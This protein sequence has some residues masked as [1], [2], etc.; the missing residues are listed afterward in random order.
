MMG[1]CTRKQQKYRHSLNMPRGRRRKTTV[2]QTL[3]LMLA[4][5]MIFLPPVESL[6]VSSTDN[7]RFTVDKVIYE[8]ISESDKTCRLVGYENGLINVELLS[9]DGDNR[10][11]D[12]QPNGYSV[13]EV[14]DEAF[15][16]C[17]TLENV[18]F[19]STI[20]QFGSNVFEGCT[21]I[22]FI[23]NG[24]TAVL[25]LPDFADKNWY[26]SAS[27]LVTSIAQG[28]AVTIGVD[29]Y[30]TVQIKK[31]S[32][33]DAEVLETQKVKKYGTVKKPAQAPE[34]E[35]Y[36][37]LYWSKNNS[38]EY[39]FTTLVE[40]DFTLVPI[41]KEIKTE[42]ECT[43][44]T[45]NY[46]ETIAE[47]FTDKT[48][49]KWYSFEPDKAG[50][51]AFKIAKGVELTDFGT[52]WDEAGVLAASAQSGTKTYTNSVEAG[53]KYYFRLHA[54]KP[55]NSPLVRVTDKEITFTFTPEGGVEPAAKTQ[56]KTL[57][58][59]MTLEY[60]STTY[61]GKWITP[62]VVVKDGSYTLVE[63]TDYTL[64]Y[65]ENRNAGKATVKVEAASDSEK[66]EGSYEMN[67]TITKAS[68][69]PNLPASKREVAS[70]VTK[71][72]DVSLSGSWQWSTADRDKTIN[73][74]TAVEATAEYTGTDKANYT[75]TT[76]KVSIIRNRAYVTSFS[77]K[78]GS[79]A[80]KGKE[81]GQ[82]EITNI[83]PANPDAYTVAWTSDNEKV[84]SVAGN[85][86]SCTVTAGQ[87]GSAVVT[88]EING[89][90]KTCTVTVTNPLTGFTLNSSQE[91]IVAGNSTIL[92]IAATTPEEPDAYTVTW[93]SSNES[94]AAVKAAENKN[95][96]KVTAVSPGT[97]TISAAVVSGG[98][99]YTQSC[100]ITVSAAEAQLTNITINPTEMNLERGVGENIDVK[101]V[102][103]KASLGTIT[104]V[105]SNPDIASV[106]EDG[107]VTAGNSGTAV[108]T[109]S[110]GSYSKTCT[111]TV[112]NAITSFELDK[113]AA[114]MKSGEQIKLSVTSVK[115][116][117]PDEYTVAWSSD[118]T[119]VVTVDDEGNVAALKT[120]TA[121]VTAS[122]NEITRSCVVT[123]ATPATGFS[124]DTDN[125]TLTEGASQG[126]GYTT[127]PENADKTYSMRWSSSDED[128]ATVA[129]GL[130]TAQAEGEADITAYM[131]VGGQEYEKTCHVTVKAV[132]TEIA[133]TGIA[134]TPEA[135]TLKIGEQK[136]INVKPV[137]EDAVIGKITYT[138]GNE[139]I[140]Q[141]DE[142]GQVTAKGS[143]QT[144]VT[145]VVGEFTKT[146]TVTV[147]KSNPSLCTVIYMDD[148]GKE[149]D[150][151]EDVAPNGKI[152]LPDIA[153]RDGCI[154]K[155]Q[156]KESGALYEPQA[157]ITV[158]KDMTFVIDV[159]HI[160][161]NSLSLA[162][163]AKTIKAGENFTL[164]VTVQPEDA[165]DKGIAWSSSNTSVATVD[166][167]GKVTGVAA[168][169]AEITAAAKDGSGKT[170]VCKVTVTAAQ[171]GDKDTGNEGTGNTG[172]GK[173]SVASIKI[174]G[175]T[176]KVAPGKKIALAAAVYPDN[177]TDKQVTWSVSDSKYASVNSSGVVTTTKAG[178]GKSVVVTAASKDGTV[179]ATY[180]IS[181]MKNAVKKVKITGK[182]SL[183]VGKSTKLKVKLT[184]NKNVSKEVAWSSSKPNVATVSSSGKVVAK[185]KGKTKITATAKDGSGKKATITITVK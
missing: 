180:K 29:T 40:S 44:L 85:G 69:P 90:R 11:T 12:V 19:P 51:F 105:S 4:A 160:S 93:K 119:D 165:F 87:S 61:T 46:T 143:G 106:D 181:I 66:Y 99:T 78:Q 151:V 137:P 139:N 145:V 150:R 126:I 156:D 1:N 133:L 140:V 161:V 148:E 76:V 171:T 47:L 131:T 97:A 49:G 144:T 86:D 129:A 122:V 115:P 39:D 185:K 73:A 67:F 54:Y 170:A 50:T 175:P 70:N 56:I 30:Y 163:S 24:S 142:E 159:Q 135:M 7:S 157:E 48:K 172:T 132:K 91:N 88:A 18:Y 179:K 92:S 111:V 164:S 94:V 95:S 104:F 6:A 117:N 2:R 80:L 158:E 149:T 26:N 79:L 5:I 120:G 121:T 130:I 31:E 17:I 75:N 64:S 154:L 16:D 32:G 65:R 109:V 153:K 57:S 72:S 53:K 3:S 113:T 123:V 38:T 114:A 108:I 147:E 177:A 141:V 174:T 34:K 10:E 41:Y 22:S 155:W 136:W 60:T 96:G 118:N 14:A 84:A 169:Q 176:K 101:P 36:T 55:S 124:L 100:S 77:L 25:T 167:S 74:E 183:K 42:P 43:P 127:I 98:T 15:K 58:G 116:D 9:G 23:Q 8:I 162:V 35:G 68:N 110:A 182:K 178:K 102:P 13:T 33:L 28:K 89:I 81:R 166:A 82:L 128:V 83:L 21:K 103:E 63:G 138:S 168:G 59:S 152:T 125:I 52:A 173:V 134:I 62:K 71:V 45:A 27:K 112:S 184:P 146:C 20:L 37:F 107:R